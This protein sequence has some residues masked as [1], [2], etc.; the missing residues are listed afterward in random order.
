MGGFIEQLVFAL[1]GGQQQQQQ[2]KASKQAGNARVYSGT[3]VSQS[4]NQPASQLVG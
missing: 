4:V 3:S 1:A 2:H